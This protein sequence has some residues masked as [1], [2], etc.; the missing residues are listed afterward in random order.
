MAKPDLRQ[1]LSHLYALLTG[2]VGLLVLAWLFARQT[3]A[4]DPITLLAFA[5]TALIVSYLRTSIDATGMEVA[6]DGAVLLGA[7]L[8]GGPA[9][10]GWVAFL[11]G[12]VTGAIPPYARTPGLERWSDKASAAML[13]AGRNVVAIVAALWAY[14]GLGPV[15][16]PMSI[17]VT[18][19]L[20]VIVLCLTYALVRYLWAW[21]VLALERA[22]S[23]QELSG[24]LSPAQFFLEF[25]PLP[26][27]LLIAA[28]FVQLGWPFFLLLVLLFIW[29]GALMRQTCESI[30]AKQAQ[31]DALHA[32]DRIRKDI[33][34]TP[35][36]PDAL[37]KLAYK[38]CT[39]AVPVPKF[40][41][42]LYDSTYTSV[43]I[44]VSVDG[45]E[46]LPT[47]RIPLTPQWEWIGECS[48]PQVFEGEAQ[49]AQLPFSVP[50]IDH[51][52]PPQA[53]MFVPL[54]SDEF[55]PSEHIGGIVMLAASPNAFPEREQAHIAEIARQIGPALARANA[56]VRQT[57]NGA[58]DPRLPWVPG[59]T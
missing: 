50:P 2:I 36:R 54:Y 33:A 5:L 25:I 3:A 53:A 51:G 45:D 32:A 44:Q 35:M 29:L 40:E 59:H 23:G 1:T 16:V 55:D 7:A 30:R 13:T 28:V 37:S 52:Q 21:P 42:G 15:T 34:A 26:A 27:A 58:V 47:M 56:V 4:V 14:R 46:R 8:V 41:L 49:M 18:H 31:I 48:A 38:L 43:H 20:A 24:V 17:E 12:L 10:G 11:I 9:L 22:A 6:L 39:E 57:H 19:S